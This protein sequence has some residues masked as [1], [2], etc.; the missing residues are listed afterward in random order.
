MATYELKRITNTTVKAEGT[1]LFV[2]TGFNTGETTTPESYGMVAGDT[3]TTE[4]EN[5]ANKTESQIKAEQTAAI[6]AYI[7]TKYPST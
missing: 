1:S 3:I 2:T 4:I 7:A 6:N 5:S